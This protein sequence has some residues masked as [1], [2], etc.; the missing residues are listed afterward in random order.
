MKQSQRDSHSCIGSLAEL[1]LLTKCTHQHP[2]PF[3]GISESPSAAQLKPGLVLLSSLL[4]NSHLCPFGVTFAEPQLLLTL[5]HGLS[6]P[7][8]FLFSADAQLL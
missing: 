2:S 8:L 5:G 1:C 7:I 6:F 3:W 4:Q